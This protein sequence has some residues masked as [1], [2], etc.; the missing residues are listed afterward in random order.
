MEGED[1]DEVISAGLRSRLSPIVERERA[2]RHRYAA[3]TRRHA[4]TFVPF[5]LDIFGGMGSDAKESYN[6][7]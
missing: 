6:T 7:L 5:V 2:K 1:E 3:M 4:M